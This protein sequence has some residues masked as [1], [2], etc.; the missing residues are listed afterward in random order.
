MELLKNE[1]ASI[2]NLAY[3]RGLVYGVGGNISV[4][5]DREVYITPKGP[6]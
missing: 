4:K 5:T 3:V 1:V 2:A 6:T